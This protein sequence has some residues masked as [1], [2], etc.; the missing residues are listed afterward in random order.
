MEKIVSALE[1]F[2]QERDSQADELLEVPPHKHS[3]LIGH[4]GQVRKALETEFGVSIDIPKKTTEGAGR[5]QVKISGQEAN[6]NK[7]KARI[8]EMVKDQEN[9]T[10]QVPRSIHHIVLDKGALPRRLRNNHSV[11]V[12]HAGKAP[13]SSPATASSRANGGAAAPLITDDDDGEDV[14]SWNIVENAVADEGEDVPWILKGKTEDV[15]KAKTILQ[16]AIDQAKTQTHRGFL[17]LPDPSTYGLVIGPGGSQI[18]SIR[19]QTGC[20]INV[21]KD[22]EKSEAIEII[23]SEEGTEFAKDLILEIVKNGRSGRA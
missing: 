10:V 9:E 8:L 5:S 1:T 3:L 16:E 7:A 6:I 12:D 14:H 23:G 15:A 19:A 20:N 22:R 21:P 13:K 11:V 17:I 18:K 2:A 4:Q